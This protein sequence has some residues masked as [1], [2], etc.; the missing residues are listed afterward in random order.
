MISLNDMFGFECLPRN[1]I[2]QL[3]INSL[4]EQLQYHYNQRM[5][6]WELLELEEEQI[7][8]STYKYHNNRSTVD[9]LMSKPHGLFFYLDDATRDRMNYEFIT[10]N[11]VGSMCVFIFDSVSFRMNL[12]KSFLRMHQQKE[13]CV[14]AESKRT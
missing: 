4:N 6:A 14:R 11:L 1:R 2:D 7:P 5:F 12:Q 10:G 8:H 9:H 3:M 13:K